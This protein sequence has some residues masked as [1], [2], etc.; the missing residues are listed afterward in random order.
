M[1]DVQFSTLPIFQI[2]SGRKWLSKIEDLRL[3]ASKMSGAARRSFQ[4]EMTLKYCDS[5]ARLAER[6]FGWGRVNI[7]VGLAER[8]SGIVCI[9]AQARYSGTK[10]WED[11]QS[12]GLPIAT[13]GQSETKKK[14]PETNPIF[15]NIKAK[16]HSSNNATVKRLSIDCKA[17]VHIGDYSRGGQT[18]G[19]HQAVD[20]DMGCEE[21]YIP[22]Q[23]LSVWL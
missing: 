21:R 9:G 10:R 3:A 1:I 6:L 15:A 18:R 11:K 14:L 2:K 22:Y 8:R 5:N 20:H 17:T 4:A 7:E 16:D 23:V 13:S 19:N 12:N